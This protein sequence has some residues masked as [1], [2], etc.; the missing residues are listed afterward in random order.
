[1]GEEFGVVLSEVTV[2]ESEAT[3]AGNDA[4]VVPSEGSEETSGV[5][6]GES[7]DAL[8]SPV[9]QSGTEDLPQKKR[10]EFKFK[11]DPPDLKAAK[12]K[13]VT[14]ILENG[15]FAKHKRPMMFFRSS[16]PQ[17]TDYES[18]EEEDHINREYTGAAYVGVRME[19]NGGR[20]PHT[21][22]YQRNFER[23][24]YVP[25]DFS[26]RWNRRP[27][28]ISVDTLMSEEDKAD[29][30]KK[31][32]KHIEEF[33]PK[34]A[35]N[36]YSDAIPED[37]IWK[38]L[39]RHLPI[40]P[41]H[42]ICPHSARM[43]HIEF[44]KAEIEAEKFRV[45]LLYKLI[46]QEGIIH[47]ER[48]WRV[49]LDKKK[50]DEYPFD[51]FTHFFNFISSRSHIFGMDQ[52]QMVFNRNML[53]TVAVLRFVHSLHHKTAVEQAP[54]LFKDLSGR[55]IYRAFLSFMTSDN[56]SFDLFFR[57]FP[58][59]FVYDE[60]DSKWDLGVSCVSSIPSAFLPE[61]IPTRDHTTTYTDRSMIFNSTGTINANNVRGLKILSDDSLRSGMQYVVGVPRSVVDNLE[62]FPVG[63]KVAFSGVRVYNGDRETVE[64]TRVEL[65]E[66]E[67]N[68]MECDG[69]IDVFSIKEEEMIV[70]E[71][72][73]SDIFIYQTREELASREKERRKAIEGIFT[74]KEE[75]HDVVHLFRQVIKEFGGDFDAFHAYLYQRP[76]Y[77]KYYQT[78]GSDNV[79][80]SLI[81]S[82]VEDKMVDLLVQLENGREGRSV[83]LEEAIDICTDICSTL[84]EEERFT[85]EVFGNALDYHK[86]LV[87]SPD[88]RPRVITTVSTKWCWDSKHNVPLLI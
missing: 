38:S 56:L 37:L 35:Q 54:R 83:R 18:D 69:T 64:G 57:N 6:E 79:F 8:E 19:S 40:L 32:R 74:N 80:M 34:G 49:Y 7:K 28:L 85:L 53:V 82:E 67:E 29:F 14:K 2:G 50:R 42:F 68:G 78:E 36:A 60:M 46:C 33:V 43:K 59:L 15:Q 4:I 45:N 48:L 71:T 16:L 58:S 65:M 9:D 5:S 61:C 10:I 39:G 75:K 22:S 51:G 41:M 77:Y 12:A 25:R 44:E 52:Q 70:K 72:V 30:L 13:N 73:S 47:I 21:S 23:R 76:F 62:K 84:M 17:N 24:P 1:N 3:M 81:P 88:T 63:A 31:K 55:L 66:E 26:H 20:L 11:S 27:Q 86:Q 87:S